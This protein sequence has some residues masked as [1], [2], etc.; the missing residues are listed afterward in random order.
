[1]VVR[2]QL[3]C[4]WDKSCIVARSA[5]RDLAREST[6]A[7]IAHRKSPFHFSTVTTRE[8]PEPIVVSEGTS[9]PYDPELKEAGQLTSPTWELELFLSG[10]FVFASFQ[11]PGVIESLFRRLEPHA[12]DAARTV[13][14]TGTLYAK[15]IAFTL[16]GTFLIHL[17]SRAQWVALL[18]LYSVYPR[19]IR[20]EEMK[21]G[22]IAKDVYRSY[23]PDLGQVVAKLDNF[24]SIVFSTGLLIVVV[25]A[26]STFLAGSLAGGAYILAQLFTHGREMQNFF[27][28]LFV[29]LVAIPVVGTLIDKRLGDRIPPQSTTYRVLHALLRVA[30][31]I[32]MMRVLG[33]MMWT[34]T[35]NIGRKRALAFLVVAL[36]A[37]IFLSAVDR[38]VQSDRLSFNSY[39]FF[40]SSREHGIR[41]Q[42]YENQ[43]DENESYARIPSIQSDIIKDPYVK[44]FIPFSPPRHNAAVARS[45]PGVKPLQDRGVQ[46]GADPYLDDS[47]VVPVL[48]CLTRLHAVTL[49]GAQ[50]PSLQFA[51]Y[52]HPRT[53][54]KGMLAYIPVDSLAHGRHVIGVMPVP[55]TE[56]PTDS[57]QLAKASWKQPF[58]IPFWR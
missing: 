58:L 9:G 38:L 13:L 36:S 16:I 57:A 51:F 34:L 37:L 53:G 21:V 44:L 7:R 56:L 24:C 17:V 12:S 29:V 23:V 43:R 6:L 18:G 31:A 10:A 19:G 15:A 39:D 2:Q 30:F 52:E 42:V 55:P 33:P 1:M 4:S 46:L 50:Q 3:L 41:Y 27:W 40:G 35:T 11:L 48:A 22:P 14:F 45:C 47:L 8:S 25:F 20:W 54:L 5:G 26:Y 49:D 28:L 32:N